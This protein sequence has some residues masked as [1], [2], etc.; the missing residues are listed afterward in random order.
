[1]SYNLNIGK[2]LV[3]TVFSK[4]VLE[5]FKNIRG[6]YFAGV[7]TFGLYGKS[8]QYDRLKEIKYIGETKGTGTCEFP[9]FI[10]DKVKQFI[11]YYYPDEYLKR[12]KMS[13][14]KMR[15][16]QFGLRELGYDYKNVLNH[17]N[18]R[19][20]YFGYT[21]NNSQDF[22]MGKRNDFEMNNIRTFKEIFEYWK[23]RWAIKRLNHLIKENK[24]KVSL[25]LKDFTLKEK[26]NEYSKQYNFEH[27][28]DKNWLKNKRDKNKI[29]YENHK[30]E[31]LEELKINMNEINV[32]EQFIQSEYLSGFFDS[33][34]SIYISKDVLFVSFSQCVLN[35]LL[36]IQKQYGGTLFKR[37]KR[38]DNQ[39]IQYTLR[40]VGLDTLN[41]LNELNKS[42]ILKLNKV[43]KGLEYIDYINKKIM[44]KKM[45]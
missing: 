32:K 22:F 23:E 15:L 7:S 42:C 10:Y 2:L 24:Y 40:I 9:I 20:I 28:N 11:K 21:S 37:N 43:K 34:G 17:G 5:Y 36:I 14:S 6:H 3:M 38:N 45:I 4:E 18:K 29:Y 26:K 1:M 8:V 12:S 41:I 19:G 44:K 30:D 33:D 16:L 39:R 35:I 31:I 13:S 27:M 25:E